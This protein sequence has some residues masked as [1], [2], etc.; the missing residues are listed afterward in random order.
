VR[1]G[2]RAYGQQK[3]CG[4]EWDAMYWSYIGAMKSTSDALVKSVTTVPDFA[5][6][7][8]LGNK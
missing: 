6:A 1:N 7:V 2:R 5:E 8:G 4:V 3:Q